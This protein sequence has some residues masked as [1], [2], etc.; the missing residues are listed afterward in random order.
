LKENSS[1]DGK[2][3]LRKYLGKTVIGLLLQ[4]SK[5]NATSENDLRSR[6]PPWEFVGRSEKWTEE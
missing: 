4:S 3:I 6:K 1:F 5:E 2:N